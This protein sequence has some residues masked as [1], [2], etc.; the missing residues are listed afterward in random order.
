MRHF[1]SVT[2]CAILLTSCASTTPVKP[3]PP[4]PPAKVSLNFDLI[5]AELRGEI[6]Q[7]QRRGTF[8]REKAKCVMEANKVPLSPPSCSAPSKYS[9]SGLTGFQLGQCIG[10]NAN[11]NQQCDYT[12]FNA[13]RQSQINVLTS[14][15]TAKGYFEMTKVE[16]DEYRAAR[17]AELESSE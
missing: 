13:S 12:A 8:I 2:L 16:Y 4:P 6:T 17:K 15:M 11:G 1:F 5:D 14:C 10:Q 7:E 3:P 9:C